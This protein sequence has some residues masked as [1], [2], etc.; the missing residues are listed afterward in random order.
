MSISSNV[1]EV[2]RKICRACEK[3][4]KD[5]K[6]VLLVAVSKQ[7]SG[8]EIRAAYE[9]GL[10]HFG[11]N[12]VD[13]AEGKREA[14]PKHSVLHLVG[15]LQSNK[16]L[17]AVQ[18]F[19][20]VH[21]VDS[22]RLAKKLDVVAKK[23]NKVQDVLVQVNVSGEGSK[24]GFSILEVKREFEELL[25]LKN[26][27]VL[28]LM[29]IAPFS[30]NSEDSRL[31]FKQLQKLRDELEEKHGVKLP[32]LSM[33]MTNDFEVAVEEGATVLRVGRALFG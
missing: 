20:V 9:A 16:V 24:Y 1:G 30:N 15:H 5:P 29:T 19:D 10:R 23:L 27:H 18:L 13:E 21:S 8:K 31:F 6:S 32:Q 17:R 4:G 3:A 33:G 28:G 14:F 12:R 26:L 25:H 7:R 11:E 2:K 22:V